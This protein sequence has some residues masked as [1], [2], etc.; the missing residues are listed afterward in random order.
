MPPN[1]DAAWLDA[2]PTYQFL[3]QALL[4]D[5]ERWNRQVQEATR[6]PVREIRADIERTHRAFHALWNRELRCARPA[7]GPVSMFGRAFRRSGWRSPRRGERV[8]AAGP[9]GVDVVTPLP[10]PAYRA[11]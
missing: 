2:V 10:D 6:G 5:T 8:S 9:T 3:V 1:P 11:K 4:G 7:S